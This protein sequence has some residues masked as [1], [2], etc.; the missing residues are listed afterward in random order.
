MQT[1]VILLTIAYEELF[2]IKF[3]PTGK[4]EFGLKLGREPEP[5]YSSWLPLD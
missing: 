3:H 2:K 5:T 1:A 4:F